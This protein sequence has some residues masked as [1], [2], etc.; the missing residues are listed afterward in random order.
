MKQLLLSGF[1]S[2]SLCFGCGNSK[3]GQPADQQS[4]S[5]ATAATDQDLSATP[6]FYV[7]LKGTLAGQALTMHL[8]KNGPN[9]FRGYYSYEKIGEP[10]DIWGSIDSSKHL[11]LFENTRSEEEITF[12]GTLDNDGTF[13]GTWRGEGTSYPFTL[14]RDFSNA[15]R[16]D[17]Y[18]S[19]DSVELKPGLKGSA[20][21][22]VS[23]A[24]IWPATNTDEKVAA[25]IRQQLIGNAKATSP[26]Q[27][28]KDQVHDFLTDYQ[29]NIITADSSNIDDD[30]TAATWNWSDEG[31][32]K[33]VWNKFPLLVIERYGYSY[34]G[35]AHGNGGSTYT[36]LDLDK[37]K[38]LK[39]T[40]IFKPG[41]QHPIEDLLATAFR[42][43][44]KMAPT[45]P[46]NSMLLVDTIPVSD[47]FYMTD[48]GVGFSYTAYEIGP[49]AMGQVTLFL[50]FTR[51]RQ[52]MKEP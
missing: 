32:V 12:N 7:Q 27:L 6:Y 20:K 31:D 14:K 36:T 40:D 21:G 13:K 46:L 52:Y 25:F 47:N 9:I 26:Q 48:K 29:G 50:P 39:I 45:D 24:I 19:S 5:T 43:K 33:V 44:Y 15:V 41:Y 37:K 3:K 23:N 2:A 35:G 16:F 4:D 18:F 42:E 49:Y 8:L 11:V 17:V 1:I 28:L 10:I 22:Q 51:I 30:F 34:T 38:V